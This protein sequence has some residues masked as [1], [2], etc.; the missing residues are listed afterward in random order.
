MSSI[1]FKF[2]KNSVETFQLILR[3]NSTPNKITPRADQ[4]IANPRLR[5]QQT[6]THVSSFEH[7]DERSTERERE[8]ERVFRRNW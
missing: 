3:E 6:E 1:S 4:K 5:E 8:R 7:F 2:V